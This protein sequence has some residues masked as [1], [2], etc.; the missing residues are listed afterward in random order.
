MISGGSAS[1]LLPHLL[2]LLLPAP[3][4]Q[5]GDVVDGTGKG[6]PPFHIA[7]ESFAVKH[8]DVGILGMANNG[9]DAPHTGATQV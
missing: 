9:P 4:S 1:P 5:G 8:D 2:L 6:I 3:H 7:D